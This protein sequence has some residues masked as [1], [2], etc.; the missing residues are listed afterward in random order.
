MKKVHQVSANSFG[1][2][3]YSSGW[4]NENQEWLNEVLKNC[5]SSYISRAYWQIILSATVLGRAFAAK[6]EQK[7]VSTQPETHKFLQVC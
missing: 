7:L 4:G 3:A 1:L 5:N 6:L 2:G